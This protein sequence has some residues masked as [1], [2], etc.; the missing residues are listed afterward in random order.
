MEIKSDK[1]HDS[2]LLDVPDFLNALKNFLDKSYEKNKNINSVNKIL[3]FLLN[4]N[5]SR[6]DVL[7]SLGGGITGDVS[8]F[9]AT[10]PSYDR[11]HQLHL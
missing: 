7:I 2:F 6:N 9:G 4:K 10:T 3:E 5:F 8:G 11:Y 1:G